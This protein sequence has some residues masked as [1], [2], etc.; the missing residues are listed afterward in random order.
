MEGGAMKSL[1]EYLATR[2]SVR[3]WLQDIDLHV[4]LAINSLQRAVGIK[5][6][7]LEIG[8]FY[9]QS[10]IL[11]GYCLESPPEEL[12]VCDPFGNTS[13]FGAE[14][15]T[16]HDRHHSDLRRDAFEKNYLRYHDRLP[17]IIEA[18]SRGLDRQK[19]EGRFR[20]IHVDGGHTYDDVREDLITVRGSLVRGGVVVLDDWSQFH[21]PGVAYAI[22]EEYARGELIPLAVTQ[23]KIYATRD[24]SAMRAADLEARLVAIPNMQVVDRHELG[25]H[26][27][28]RYDL[29][30]DS[31]PAAAGTSPEP[32][33]GLRRWIG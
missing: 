33:R 26:V 8:T 16:H 24:A 11:L 4:F 2:N 12:W 19:L 9:G 3:G 27:V 28:P 22:W 31:V 13:G 25:K 6:D 5:G 30:P 7:M 1:E 20:M 10:A 15:L 23:F 29:K 32:R 14:S 18:P 17:I 21:V